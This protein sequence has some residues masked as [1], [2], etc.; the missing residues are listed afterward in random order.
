MRLNTILM[1]PSLL[2]TVAC[3]PSVSLPADAAPLALT[4]AERTPASRVH[5]VQA[6]AGLGKAALVLNGITG[7]NST[8]GFKGS[9]DSASRPRY[10]DGGSGV[11]PRGRPV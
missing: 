5:Q 11:P 8:T 9:N 1:R 2:P 6:P 10:T 3:M 4:A 7:F